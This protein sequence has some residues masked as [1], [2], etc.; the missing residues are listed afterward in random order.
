MLASSDGVLDKVRTREVTGAFHSRKA[1][2]AAA[3]E[4]LVA[5]FDRAD[6]DVSASFDE[7]QR[8]LSYSA[9]PPPDLADIPAAPRRPFLG[10]DD[11]KLADAVVSCIAGCAAAVAMAFFL[12]VKD[13][14]P[15]PVGILSVLTG[16]IVGGAAVLW[17]RRRLQ[18]ERTRGLEKLAE[19][20]GLL[21]G[22]RVRSPERETKAQELLMRHGGEAVHIHEIDL[23]KRTE[24]LRS[25]HCVLIPGSV[26]NGSGNHS[27]APTI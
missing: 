5:G 19:A 10:E 1:L 23:P 16:L 12:V 17:A 7:L 27:A 20:H 13:L 14:R 6:I 3:E 2:I 21:I 18:R 4:L 11:V 15:I 26:T 22:V 9:I 25:N 8:R 24:D